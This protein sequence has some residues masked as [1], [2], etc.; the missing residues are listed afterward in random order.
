MNSTLLHPH[1][2]LLIIGALV[3]A[4]HDVIVVLGG[5]IFFNQRSADFFGVVE[6]VEFAREWLGLL[7]LVNEGFAGDQLFEL[8]EILLEEMSNRSVVCQHHA[9]DFV[10]G[11][12]VG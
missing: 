5:R 10:L 1:I 8:G 3:L 6:F 4:P 11:L 2:T 12:Y 7:V 9:T